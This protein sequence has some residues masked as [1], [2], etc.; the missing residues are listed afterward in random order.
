MTEIIA[1]Y[2]PTGFGAVVLLAIWRMIVKPQLDAARQ[3]RLREAQ[4]SRE[5]LANAA[6]RL[7][8]KIVEGNALLRNVHAAVIDI[9]DRMRERDK[10]E[11]SVRLAE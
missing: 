10:G 4:A 7:E 5:A 8:A 9:P 6:N 3:D 11:G 1:A 2:G